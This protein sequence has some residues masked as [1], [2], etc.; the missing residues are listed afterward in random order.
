MSFEG[1]SIL[2]THNNIAL[3]LLFY[4]P[5]YMYIIVAYI[6]YSSHNYLHI[7]KLIVRVLTTASSTSEALATFF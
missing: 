7:F 2:Y 3:S 5:W 6:F 1:D 4:T